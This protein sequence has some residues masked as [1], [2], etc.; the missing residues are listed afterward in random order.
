MRITIAAV[1][2]LKG[3]ER[4]LVDRYV[5]RADKAGRQLGLRVAV[6]EI[7]ESRAGTAAARKNQEAEALL[8]AAPAGAMLIALDE[9]GKSLD[10]TTFADEIARWRDTGTTDLVLVIG[11]P[12]GHGGALAARA[13]LL[14]SLGPMTWPH[15][16]ARLMIAEQVYRAVT[17]LAGHP[18]HRS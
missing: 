12:D 16:F 1:G 3:P 2:R 5:D 8:A 4:E 10:S 18:Y 13:G 6:R 9:K 7:P 11:G 17:I 14:L 15:Q